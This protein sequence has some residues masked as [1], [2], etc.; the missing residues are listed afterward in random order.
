[1]AAG[2]KL[3]VICGGG[4]E[5]EAGEAVADANVALGEG[6]KVFSLCVPSLLVL[7]CV[8]VG[9]LENGVL[10]SVGLGITGGDVHVVV[11]AAEGVGVYRGFRG[12]KRCDGDEEDCDGLKLRNYLDFIQGGH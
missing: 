2:A 1:M 10:E 11:L 9:G 5:A 3:V 4:A 7:P 8:K 12:R 6:G